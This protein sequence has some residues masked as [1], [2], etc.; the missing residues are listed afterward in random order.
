MSSYKWGLFAVSPWLVYLSISAIPPN[1]VLG[2]WFHID[3][4]RNTLGHT[5]TV[6]STAGVSVGLRFR[7]LCRSA[8]DIIFQLHRPEQSFTRR[9]SATRLML[10]MNLGG[11]ACFHHRSIC[12]RDYITAE[13]L[14]CLVLRV[15]SNCIGQQ[16]I[17]D[18][19]FLLCFMP[20]P[21]FFSKAA[22]QDSQFLHSWYHKNDIQAGNGDCYLLKTWVN[23]SRKLNIGPL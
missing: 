22:K 11:V 4:Q 18:D 2:H 8:A 17:I 14:I 1:I 9:R 10:N 6:S 3:S 5:A 19:C 23:Q 13:E 7:N 20:V 21:H 16:K 15:M 12:S